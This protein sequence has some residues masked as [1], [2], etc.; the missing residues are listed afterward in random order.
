MM[1]HSIFIFNS[2]SIGAFNSD[3]IV[4][5]V[6]QANLITLCRQYGLSE[7]LIPNA[8]KT[9]RVEVAPEGNLFALHARVDSHAPIIVSQITDDEIIR[10]IIGTIPEGLVPAVCSAL[11]N[12]QALVTVDLLDGHL[13]DLGLLFAYEVARWAA[14]KGQGLV[15]GLDQRWYRLNQHKAYIPA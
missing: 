4:I 11:T 6:T 5:A 12:A 3:A 9:L 13:R 2:V 15:Y 10:E 8:L 7:T 1:P 14:S